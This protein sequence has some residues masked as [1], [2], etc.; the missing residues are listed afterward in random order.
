MEVII[1]YN[2]HIVDTHIKIHVIVIF[3]LLVSRAKTIL[4][5]VSI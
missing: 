5:R 3:D 4:V 2:N 1:Q